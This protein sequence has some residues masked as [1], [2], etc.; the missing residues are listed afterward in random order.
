MSLLLMETVKFPAFSMALFC[1][2]SRFPYFVS[3]QGTRQ[4]P[5]FYVL[6]EGGSVCLEQAGSVLPFDTHT[7]EV[8]SH[9]RL[10][11]SPYASFPL[12]KPFPSP[13]H[14]NS[15]KDLR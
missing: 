10:C 3:E 4:C 13:L 9:Q 11:A 12:A 14:L 6:L 2:S 5:M 15:S 8:A 7:W 1:P